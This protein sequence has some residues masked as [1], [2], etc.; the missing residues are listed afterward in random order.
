MNWLSD[1]SSW[2]Y[3]TLAA[4][5]IYLYMTLIQSMMKGNIAYCFLQ[6]AVYWPQQIPYDTLGPLGALTK[7]LVKEYHSYMYKGWVS[8]L[9]TCWS[10]SAFLLC[11]WKL[12]YMW[13]WLVVFQ[14]VACLGCP[15]VWI[16]GCSESLQVSST[17]NVMVMIRKYCLSVEGIKHNNKVVWL[18]ACPKVVYSS[19]TRVDCLLK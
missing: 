3:Y 10:L 12:W 13:S 18:P 19:C 8:C 17:Q 2:S 4:I 9:Y 1:H 14:M 5:V 11:L 6:W 16:S 15:S 7:H